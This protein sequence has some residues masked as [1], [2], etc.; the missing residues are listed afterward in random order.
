[1]KIY[2]GMRTIIILVTMKSMVAIMLDGVGNMR[3]L[4]VGQMSA[5]IYLKKDSISDLSM[6]PISDLIFS[7][8]DISSD[9]RY[10]RTQNPAQDSIIR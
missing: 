8:F 6:D 3:S 9:L 4:S 5:C 7:R 10:D 1:M 2:K